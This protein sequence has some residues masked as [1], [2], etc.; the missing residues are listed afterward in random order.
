MMDFDGNGSIS[1]EEAI[2]L[3][4]NSLEQIAGLLEEIDQIINDSNGSN[5]EEKKSL[6]K[7]E[8]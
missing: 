1:N 7:T 6:F 8:L 4:I 2:E 5:I 3:D